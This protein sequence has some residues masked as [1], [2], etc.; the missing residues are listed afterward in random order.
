MKKCDTEWFT[1]LEI[2]DVFKPIWLKSINDY[3]KSK[4]QTTLLKIDF[5]KAI[6]NLKIPI[7][8]REGELYNQE[9]KEIMDYITRFTFSTDFQLLNK[10]ITKGDMFGVGIIGRDSS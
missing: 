8:L 4:G 3:I 7:V 2:D 1:I 10:Y 9:K 5:S 6:D